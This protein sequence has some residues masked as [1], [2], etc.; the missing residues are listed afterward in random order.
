MAQTTIISFF[1]YSGFKNKW[2]ALARMGKPPISK[3]KL[4]GYHFL[5]PLAPGVETD[6]Q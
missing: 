5:S 3:K 2:K 4:V 6:F 1:K